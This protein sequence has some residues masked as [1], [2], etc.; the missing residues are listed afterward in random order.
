MESRCP[1][2]PLPLHSPP[3]SAP[4]RRRRGALSLVARV[5]VIPIAYGDDGTHDYK[6]HLA[7]EHGEESMEVLD[8]VASDALARPRT[9]MVEVVHAHTTVVAVI[10]AARYGPRGGRRVSLCV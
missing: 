6:H 1:L 7:A 5:D 2:S 10:G 9:M 8:I 4:S 3:L